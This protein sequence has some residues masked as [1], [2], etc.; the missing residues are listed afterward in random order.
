MIERMPTRHGGIER[1]GTLLIISSTVGV[2]GR[3]RFPAITLLAGV[4][5]IFP[6]RRKGLAGAWF[7]A[8]GTWACGGLGVRW[9]GLCLLTSLQVWRI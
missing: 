2:G 4:E 6:S 7:S 9:R 1:R 8:I 3:I 5:P